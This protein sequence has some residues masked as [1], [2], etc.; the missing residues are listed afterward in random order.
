MDSNETKT[1]A[2]VQPAESNVDQEINM[3]IYRT[4]L[5]VLNW[6]NLAVVLLALFGNTLIVIIMA[7]PHNRKSSTSIFF[8]GLAVSDFLLVLILPFER[9]LHWATG[10]TVYTFSPTIVII[11]VILNYSVLQISTWILACITIERVLSVVIPHKIK[12]ICTMERS[13]VLLISVILFI[14]AMYTFAVIVLVDVTYIEEVGPIWD[15]KVPY[16]VEII[17]WWDLIMTLIVPFVVILIGSAVIIT[18]LTRA[19]LQ[20]H[21]RRSDRHNPVTAKLLAANVVFIITMSPFCIF[22]YFG[23]TFSEKPEVD[24]LVSNIL[25]LLSDSNAA[26]NFFVYCLSGTRFRS[27]V[28]KVLCC[29]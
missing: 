28:K 22:F 18:Q 11:K 19:S 7:L 29:K 14:L 4:G 27:D 10:K 17:Q 21:D 8:T 25:L 1:N 20:K 16:G 24:F 9:W 6:F 12:T 23:V 13:L 5:S 15:S 2:S 26:W 3:E